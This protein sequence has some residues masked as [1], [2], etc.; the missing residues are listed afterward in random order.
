M[1]DIHVV[2]RNE[3]IFDGKTYRCAV[4]LNGFTDTPAEGGKAT[5][6]ATIAVLGLNDARCIEL[7]LEL[8]A[9]ERLA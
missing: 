8:L 9:L 5:R 3:L 4:G 7:R 1:P 6:R 2:S